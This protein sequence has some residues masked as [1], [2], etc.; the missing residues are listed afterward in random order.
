MAGRRGA[1]KLRTARD[2][3]NR[4]P[5]VVFVIDRPGWA[6]DIVSRNVA[7]QLAD[8]YEFTIICQ[9]ER[10]FAEQ[11]KMDADLFIFHHLSMAEKH[12]TGRR[13]LVKL[14]G[15]R[16]MDV[17]LGKGDKGKD[18]IEALLSGQ[19]IVTT[20]HGLTELASKYSPNVH[21]IQN[22]LDLDA[23]SPQRTMAKQFTVGFCGS[24][25]NQKRIRYKGFSYVDVACETLGMPLNVSAYNA[26]QDAP[27]LPY[28]KMP[29]YYRKISCLVHPSMQEGSSNAI[30]EALAC[31]IPVVTT[32]VGYHGEMLEDRRDAIFVERNIF[33]IIE[34]LR[35][36][37]ANPEIA[38]R[39]GAA[40][41][42]FAE[43]HHDIRKVAQLWKAAI[44]ERLA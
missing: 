8:D 44:E 11:I 2:Q 24:V 6:Y 30:M 26:R 36:L 3:A 39:Y 28:H 31:G 38:K 21:M 15:Y 9:A 12:G 13:Y 29:V 1:R 23:F 37:K 4:K 25:T 43:Q 41:R 40:A 17:Y 16:C 5:H 35:R 19:H 33:E 34:M 22:G 7:A 14:S 20:N 32:K 27:G 18:R 10:G 42:A